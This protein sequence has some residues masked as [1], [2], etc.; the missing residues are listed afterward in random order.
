MV[1]KVPAK[2]KWFS[3][4][5]K[6]QF[7][8]ASKD[9]IDFHHLGKPELS[10]CAVKSPGHFSS[11]LRRDERVDVGL[12]DTCFVLGSIEQIIRGE[13]TSIYGGHWFLT[14]HF[15]QRNS[16]LA[17][18]ALY[19]E[20]LWSSSSSLK[21]NTICTLPFKS[22]GSPRQFRV[23]HENSHFYWSNELNIS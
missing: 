5:R 1:G 2:K 15:L 13:F 11:M 16:A 4:T 12:S 10:V 18:M 9:L 6:Q 19:V 17:S 3:E 14:M 8:I 22:L 23:F 21:I 20:P 7:H